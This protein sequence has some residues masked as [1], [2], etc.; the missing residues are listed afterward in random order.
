MTK[1]DV[2][3][4]LATP[5]D[6]RAIADI[7]NEA[8]VGTTATFDTEPKTEEDRREWIQDHREGYAVL[9]AERAG[10]VV[11]WAALSRWSDR[12]AYAGTA[13]TS[14]Y[15]A[16]KHRGTGIGR[17]LKKRLIDEARKA[18][19]HT[20]LARVAES[21]AVSRHLNES[22]GFVHVGTM[23]EVGFKFGQWLDVEIMQLMLDDLRSSDAT[24]TDVSI[25]PEHPEDSAEIGAVVEAAFS[26]S[27]LGHH[28]EADLVEH[29]RNSCPEV[30]SLVATH[31]DH[32][33]GHVLFSPAM[34][35]GSDSLCGMGL[36]P[37]AV[38]PAF[39]RRGIGV[40]LIRTGIEA[41]RERRCS[42]IC[43]LGWPDYYSRFGFER[44]Q[45]FG[46]DSEFGGAADGTFQILWLS[47]RPKTLNGVVRYRPE[48]S[49]LKPGQPDHRIHI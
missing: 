18:G 1:S 19:F 44:A 23:R 29:L 32:V 12:P 9:V 2:A 28:G 38:L 21:S 26:S 4:R 6:A 15:V 20:I 41:L 36:G 39:Q 35:D 3:I 7:Y 46:I 17:L 10:E 24:Q 22:L 37:V 30:L 42:F 11:G 45:Q 16:Q 49:S 13:E 34:I 14:F 47:D 25:H 43:V 40:Q 33:V 31:D 48:F 8:I 27:T 5:A